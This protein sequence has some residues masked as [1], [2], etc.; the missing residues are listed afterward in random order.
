MKKKKS[1][2]AVLT[3]FGEE[4]NIFQGLRNGDEC[5]LS[6]LQTDNEWRKL[7]FFFV[8]GGGAVKYD[9]VFLKT[10]S[11]I[12]TAARADLS[13]LRKAYL[14]KLN[15]YVL[16]AFLALPI[17]IIITI[18]F[19]LNVHGHRQSNSAKQPTSIYGNTRGTTET[20][21]VTSCVS[22]LFLVATHVWINLLW[23]A[24]FTAAPGMKGADEYD[25][26]N[27]LRFVMIV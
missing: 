23:L 25:E 20:R 11:M 10:S 19:L 18:R 6:E 22:A 26:E 2:H 24:I 13:Y 8:E 4:K 21:I 5:L 12:R 1:F 7:F 9:A 27:R 15:S 17:I 16:L 14:V 3:M